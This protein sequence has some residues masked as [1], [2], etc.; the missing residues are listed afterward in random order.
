[1]LTLE[2][3]SQELQ[4]IKKEHVEFV[5]GP[6]QTYENAYN[7]ALKDVIESFQSQKPRIQKLIF[8]ALQQK[9]HLKDVVS[10]EQLIDTPTQELEIKL[11]L[12]NLFRAGY[13]TNVDLELQEEFK[14][15]PA[16]EVLDIKRENRN[17]LFQYR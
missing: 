14:N 5:T 12:I 6:S 1:M 4:T 3:I 15:L 16:S 10:F 17:P 7:K 8:Q 13:S 2:A 9:S 11:D